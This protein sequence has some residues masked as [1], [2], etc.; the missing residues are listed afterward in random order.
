MNSRL[1]SRQPLRRLTSYI[2][3]TYRICN[4]GFRYMSSLNPRRVLT[5]PAQGVH[6]QNY[7]NTNFDLI[8]YVNDIL[9]LQ[10]KNRFECA[11]L[12]CERARFQFTPF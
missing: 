10:T 5:K 7:D 4:P 3:D 9:G 8:L 12:Q 11:P 2:N 1:Q 6:N